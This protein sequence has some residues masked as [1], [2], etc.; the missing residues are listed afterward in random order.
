MIS[1]WIADN[2]LSSRERE[3]RREERSERLE[4]R[5][6]DFQRDTLLNLQVASQKF[7]RATGA[8]HFQDVI[9]FRETG[10]WQKGQFGEEL[11]NEHLRQLTET[12]LLASRV[13]DD[14]ARALA[15]KLRIGATAVSASATERDAE[16]QMTIV[17]DIQQALIERIGKLVREM[18]EAGGNAAPSV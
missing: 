6:T 18:D 11:S 15:G 12:M 3:R 13:W 4:A 16:H 5:R 2:R 17:T 14:E 7:M 1:A 10:A 9:A 8:M